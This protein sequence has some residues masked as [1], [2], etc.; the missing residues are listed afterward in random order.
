MKRSIC[1]I[2]L[3]ILFIGCSNIEYPDGFVE[4]VLFNSDIIDIEKM[5]IT[6]KDELINFVDT[7][8]Y[9]ARLDEPFWASYRYKLVAL[10]TYEQDYKDYTMYIVSSSNKKEIL[11]KSTYKDGMPIKME[12]GYNFNGSVSKQHVIC[13]RGKPEWADSSYKGF[14]VLPVA[15]SGEE[16]DLDFTWTVREI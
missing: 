6:S 7:T 2:V 9:S 16:N 11:D 10:V 3:I 8:S 13:I 14:T 1:F 12:G 15:N 4:Q 5:R